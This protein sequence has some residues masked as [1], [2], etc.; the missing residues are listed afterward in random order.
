MKPHRLLY[1]LISILIAF[2][3]SLP[4]DAQKKG[5]KSSHNNKSVVNEPD[6]LPALAKKHKTI[7]V[8]EAQLSTRHG[9]INTKSSQGI[10]V[11]HYQGNIDWKRVAEQDISYAYIKAT[12]GQG[13]I[14]EYYEQNIR[15][16]RKAGISASA[17]HFYRP[18]IA[19]EEQFALMTSVV[20]QD[21]LDLV[22]LIDIEVMGNVSRDK[23]IKDLREFVK[24]VT[25]HYGKKP[26]LYTFHNFYNKNLVGEF[27]DY[28]W[29][30]AR[31]RSDE[32][33]LD[34]NVKYLM[35]QYSST[36]KIDGI[37]GNVDRSCL[38][39]KGTLHLLQM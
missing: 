39:D 1:I 25:K 14:D 4:A 23:F 20:K 33:W 7:T 6:K 31:Y 12:E 11:S 35:W 37:R 27:K 28:H 21:D 22:P 34:D 3:C 17:Y 9:N 5:K 18:N 10:D 13:L 8:S 26:L 30:I 32:P 15:E 36:S 29:M 16:A 2:G 38:M 19:W 24:A